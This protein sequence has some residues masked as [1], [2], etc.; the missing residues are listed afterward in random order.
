MGA[1]GSCA[2]RTLQKTV[3]ALDVYCV[4]FVA[5]G[6]AYVGKTVAAYEQPFGKTYSF[7]TL[8]FNI[9][10]WKTAVQTREEH[11]HR[12]NTEMN[13]SDRAVSHQRN[14]RLVL[15]GHRD[16]QPDKTK[17][18]VEYYLFFP[19]P[20]DIARGCTQKRFIHG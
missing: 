8:F 6:Q 19:H 7:K 14:V 9:R 17:K 15:G 20:V 11:K 16:P 2:A 12:L 3:L 10:R 1:S 18:V 5:L 4:F 13:Q